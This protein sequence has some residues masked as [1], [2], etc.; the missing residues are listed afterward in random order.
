MPACFEH[1]TRADHRQD[2]RSAVAKM[3]L[4]LPGPARASRVANA[5][6]GAELDTCARIA[7]SR[8]SY[9][10]RIAVTLCA[11]EIGY[12]PVTRG[13]PAREQLTRGAPTAGAGA[14]GRRSNAIGE[15]R[16]GAGGAWREGDCPRWC[17]RPPTG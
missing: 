3:H 8:G 9:D 5:L 4:A 2:I 11:D 12:L 1:Q 15:G 14:S 7:T 16:S 13:A 17:V 6:I 10:R